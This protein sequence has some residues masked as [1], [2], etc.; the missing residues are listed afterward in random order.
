MHSSFRI[1]DSITDFVL[2]WTDPPA[3][4]GANPALINDLDLVVTS[5]DQTYFGNNF[6]G[7]FSQ[8]FGDKDRINNVE[9]VRL[10]GLSEPIE[11]R[12]QAQTIRGDGVPNLPDPSDQDF[13]LAIKGG[14]L[15]SDRCVL[16]SDSVSAPPR[17]TFI[18]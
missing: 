1:P 3:A 5:T 2:V 13:A 16:Q 18:C 7:Q 4:P 14:F 12:V 10:I 15:V 17:I 6:Q 8:P 11:V 9:R